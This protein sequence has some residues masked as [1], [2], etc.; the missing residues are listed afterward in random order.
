MEKIR[1]LFGT[2][3]SIWYR[4]WDDRL[5]YDLDISCKVSGAV[6]IF[7]YPEELNEEALNQTVKETAVSAVEECLHNKP[8]GRPLYSSNIRQQAILGKA[9]EDALLLKGIRAEAEIVN[10]TLE[11]ESK[12]EIDALIKEYIKAATPK[13]YVDEMYKPNPFEEYY[14]QNYKD[15]DG[16]MNKGLG[17]ASVDEPCRNPEVKKEETE[18][19]QSFME[20]MGDVM[21]MNSLNEGETWTCPNCKNNGNKGNFCTECGAKRPPFGSLFQGL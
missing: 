14:R 8:S 19:P 13:M 6:T 2:P 11:N 20:M 7:E 5:G 15:L 21:G 9:I 3:E 10:F 16:W 17:P 1:V 4:E 12:E 18:Q